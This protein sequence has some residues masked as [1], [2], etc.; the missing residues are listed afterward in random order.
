MA[1]ELIG[2]MQCFGGVMSFDSLRAVIS[3]PI[4]PLGLLLDDL[5]RGPFSPA[6]GDISV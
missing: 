3:R 2:I 6:T 4:L 5:D 1:T